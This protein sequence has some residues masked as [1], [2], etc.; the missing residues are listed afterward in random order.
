MT[1]SLKNL[2]RRRA[3]REDLAKLLL[4]VRDMEDRA[5]VIVSVSLLENALEDMLREHTSDLSKSE[6]RKL[7]DANGPL[8]TLASKILI[9][10]AFR[11]IDKDWAKDLDKIREIRNAFAH[12]PFSLSF[13]TKEITTSIASL[14]TLDDFLHPAFSFLDSELYDLLAGVPRDTP[15]AK[16]LANCVLFMIIFFLVSLDPAYFDTDEV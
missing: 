16:F 8:A 4:E 12:S 15:R 6:K 5:A 7:F 2:R 13:K 11:L 10:R 1:T 9:A 14:R 3:K